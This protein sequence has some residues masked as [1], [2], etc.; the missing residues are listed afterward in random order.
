MT[1]EVV[2]TTPTPTQGAQPAPAA[3]DQN[4]AQPAAAEATA[5]TPKEETPEQLEEK[6]KQKE[7]E[8]NQRRLQRRSREAAEAKAEAKL[9][10]EENERLRNENSA[11]TKG[12]DEPQR[13]GINPKTGAEYTYEEYLEARADWR[14]DQRVDERLKK[15]GEAQQ[16]KEQRERQT[17]GQEEIAKQ[18]TEREQAFQKVTKDY[19][20]VVGPYADGELQELHQATR[21]AIAESEKGPQLLDHLARNPDVHA[22][23]SELSPLRQVA[24]L[25]KLEDKLAAPTKKTTNAPDPIR[26]VGSRASGSKDLEKM[27][28]AEYEAERKARGARW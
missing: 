22:R 6:R 20:D 17:Q 11:R 26:P 19:A 8:H 10:R 14:A 23:I 13:T 7:R 12:S 15:V 1:D 4:A 9:L 28:Q 5:E 3:E 2:T 24:E 25:G 27:T 18:W 16:G 21:S